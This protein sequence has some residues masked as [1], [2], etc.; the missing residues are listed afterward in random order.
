MAKRTK[1]ELKNYFQA[2]KRPTESQFE[3]FIDSYMHVNKNLHGD[4]IDLNFEFLNNENNCAI[5]VLFGNTYINGVITLEIVGSYSHQSSVGNIKKQFQIGANPDH[6]VWY[7]TTS[8]LV[9]AEG[10]ILDNIYIGNLEWDS[11]INQYKITIY[12][13]ASTGNPYNLRVSQQSQGNLVLDQVT[14]SAI[15]TKSV[16]GQNR[17]FVNYNENVGI[18]TKNPQTKLQIVSSLSDPNEPGTVIIGEVHQPN[19][20]LGYNSQYSWIQSHAGAPLHINSVGN[21]VVF[22]KDAGNVGIGIEN[23][24][25]KLDVNGFVT[26]KITS[27]AVNPS[28]TSGFSVNE[29]G[30][31]VLEMSYTRDG[32][33]IGMIK[34]LSANHIA[35]GT[36]NTERL[37]INATTGN[38]G[39]G[40][41]NP[42]QKLTVK[43]KI[44]AEDVIV[45]MNVPA[46]YVFQKYYDNH[47]SI[48]EDY[49]MMNLNELEAFIKEN[50]H[51][52]E[53]PSG[54]KMTQDGVTL[55]DFQMKL[56]QKIEE[57]T[58]YVISLKKEVDTL[59]LN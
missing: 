36:N 2:G 56:L 53:I 8:R 28:N 54:E 50:K 29:L 42:D 24:Q 23:P 5:D 30:T 3:D 38:V 52:P 27:G 58:L 39:I 34:T 48:R 46:D 11:V 4:Y 31:N 13:T 16:N 32:Q 41:Q 51:L 22:N 18:G 1:S 14:L 40:T 43:G 37:R 44:H 21:N 20:R 19:L 25:T 57:L 45:N 6:S 10:T 17:H 33:G 35:I 12:H 15:Y 26:S 7:S 49:S 47:S 59:K 9:E 55:G